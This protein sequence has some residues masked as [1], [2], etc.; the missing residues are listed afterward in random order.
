MEQKKLL[1]ADYIKTQLL[2]WLIKQKKT[3]IFANE[4]LFSKYKRRADLICLLRN[5]LI[6]YEIKGYLDNTSK[7]KNQI[8]DYIKTFDKVFVI[9]TKNHLEN[10]STKLQNKNI[11]IILYGNN[12]NKFKII[13]NAKQNMVRKEDLLYLMDKNTLI[14]ELGLKEKNISMDRIRNIAIKILSLHHIKKLSYAKL[15]MRY[16]SLFQLF[17]RDRS[18]TTSFDDLLNLTGFVDR[19]R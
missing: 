3:A 2:D 13:K 6:A 19:L 18:N 10:I 12:N 14:K 7:L 9:T 4:V 11:G 8:S 15:Y 5:S 16:S 1:S 17:M